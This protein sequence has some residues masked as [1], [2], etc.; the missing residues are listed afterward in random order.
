MPLLLVIL[1][2][3]DRPFAVLPAVFAF[4]LEPASGPGLLFHTLPQVF[5]SMPAGAL[6]GLLFFAGLLGAAW[7][8]A[9]ACSCSGCGSSCPARLSRSGSGGS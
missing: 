7:L 9:V 5:A 4:G 3:A 8:S 2:H 1:W 6:F